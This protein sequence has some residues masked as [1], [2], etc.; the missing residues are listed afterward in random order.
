M[1]QKLIFVFLTAVAGC[2]PATAVAVSTDSLPEWQRVD[3]FRDGQ[4]APHAL[5]VPYRTDDVGAVADMAFDKSPYYKSLNGKWR[6]NWTRNVD[7]RPKGFQN[8]DY[9]TS[10]WKLINVPGNWEMQG[11]GTPV[12]TNTTYEFD[13]DWAEFRK[14][15]PLVPSATNEVGSY[16]RTFTVP[17]DW[18]GR[19][20]VLCVEGAIS[21]YYAW[22]NGHYLGCNMDSKTAAEWDITPYLNIDGDNTVALEVYRW[23]AG[24]YFECQDYWRISGI[25]RDVYLY[26]TPPTYVS[27]LTVR[28]PLDST[29]T[30]GELTIEASVAGLFRSGSGRK[31][32]EKA[33]K[34]AKPWTLAYKLLSPDGDVVKSGEMRASD[35]NS[36]KCTVPRVKPWSAEHPNLY[37]LMLDLRNPAGNVVETVGCNVGFKTVEIKNS[38]VLVNGVPVLVKGVNRHAHSDLGHTVPEEVALRDVEIMKQNNINTVRNSH[39]PQDRRWYHLADKYGLYIIDEVNAES[40]GYGYGEESLAKRAEWIPAVTDRTARMYAKSKNNPSVTFYSLGNECGNGIV[41]E[42]TYKWLKEREHNRPVQYERA[43]D[44]PNSDIYALMYN[45]VAGIRAYSA[46]STRMRPNILCEYAHAMGNSVGGLVDYWDAFETCP[47]LQGGCIWDWVDQGFRKTDENGVEYWAYGGDFG[48]ANV[49]SDNSFLYNGLIRADRTP[50]PHLQEVKK[51]YQNI[52][53]RLTDPATLTVEVKNWHDFT[54]LDRFMLKWEVVD[55]SGKVLQKGER[56]VKCAPRESVTVKLG[57]YAGTEAP[58]AFLNLSWT[59][60]EDKP[61]VSKDFEVAYDQF[62]LPGTAVETPDFKPLKLKRKD[63]RFTCGDVSFTV[64]PKTGEILSVQNGVNEM[65]ATPVSLSLWRPLTEN[66]AAYWSLGNQIWRPQGLDSISQRL[67]SLTTKKNVVTVEADIISA[68]GKLLGKARY[69]YSVSAGNT[70]DVSCRFEPDTSAVKSLP[71][72]GLTFR[73]PKFHASTVSYL[74]RGPVETYVDRMQAGRIGTYVTTPADDFHDYVVPSATGNHTET[75]WM[76]LDG[77]GLKIFSSG[78]FQFSAT[79]YDDRVIDRARHTCDLVDDRLVTVHVDAAH[80]G[81]GTGTCGPDI[82][83]KYQI[84]VEPIDFTF[85]FRLGN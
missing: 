1:M 36:F 65:T 23:S 68:A 28:S 72:V 19:R 17:S 78:P 69:N 51:V 59:P 66:D 39:Y 24:A 83:P 42:E 62:V 56:N 57:D 63:N 45:S 80:T 76:Q 14:N 54:D 22:V 41:F 5:V 18:A 32:H 84:P 3:A 25:E 71:R 53:S 15:A 35:D 50:H 52:K 12:Y 34:K 82:L 29:Y 13:S 2:L 8:K 26:S 79:P 43:L 46:D 33:A 81:V 31:L 27:D 6:F 10:S 38:Q 75:R 40:H 30:D 64:S 11:Y 37:T 73:V 60:V 16:L 70:L 47:K 21:F 58:E 55:P 44:D 49:P 9:D 85:H 67:M 20:V 77:S 7:L 61:F 74:G 4:I 48:P